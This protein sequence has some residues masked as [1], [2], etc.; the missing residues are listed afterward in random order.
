[1]I[2]AGAGVGSGVKYLWSREEIEYVESMVALMD[3]T[4][5]QEA[6]FSAALYGESV[7][8]ELPKAFSLMQNSPN[9]FNP[10]TTIAFSVPEAMP[11]YVSLEV[12]DL[13]GRM[14]RTLVEGEREAGS[15]A[16]FWDGTDNAGRKVPSGVYF[17]RIQAGNYS[18]TRKMVLLK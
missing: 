18:Q 15:Y 9:P 2:L 14:V 10:S 12:F 1:M 4:P 6:L 5:E 8:A 3:L 13:R 16:V 11:A 17:Y 7:S